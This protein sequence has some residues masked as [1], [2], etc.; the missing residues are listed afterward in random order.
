MQSRRRQF[1]GAFFLLR[2][3]KK[4]SEFRVWRRLLFSELLQ[5]LIVIVHPSIKFGERGKKRVDSFPAPPDSPILCWNP[6]DRLLLAVPTKKLPCSKQGLKRILSWYSMSTNLQKTMISAACVF[7]L[8]AVLRTKHVHAGQSPDKDLLTKFCAE[9]LLHAMSLRQRW[10]DALR[11]AD[12]HASPS[13]VRLRHQ[14]IT[15]FCIFAMGTTSP[16][17]RPKRVNPWDP[18]NSLQRSPDLPTERRFRQ[19]QQQQYK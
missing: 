13:G 3:W 10:G 19:H 6:L 4:A 16:E 12:I 7:R 17:R 5:Q 1:S 14:P 2:P 8:K 18:F 15:I 9:T 11:P